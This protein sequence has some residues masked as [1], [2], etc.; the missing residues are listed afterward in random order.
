MYI[1]FE[2]VID[3]VQKYVYLEQTLQLDRNS[4][5]DEVDNRIQLSWTAFGNRDR[6][7][8]SHSP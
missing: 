7:L 3:V 8:P 2:F 5:E 4:F 6:E 1:R